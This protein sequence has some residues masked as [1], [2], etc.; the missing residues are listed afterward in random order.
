[1]SFS[2]LS[3]FHP[4]LGGGRGKGLNK[5][6]GSRRPVWSDPA[7]YKKKTVHVGLQMLRAGGLV[8]MKLIVESSTSVPQQTGV[9]KGTKKRSR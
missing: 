9:S 7:E 6:K 3:T 8:K 4:K 2:V 5:V 1:M